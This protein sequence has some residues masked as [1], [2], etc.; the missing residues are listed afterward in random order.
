MTSSLDHAIP[1][2]LR[3]TRTAL[4]AKP[5]PK[6]YDN[7]FE[8]LHNEGRVADT[9]CEYAGASAF[10]FPLDRGGQSYIVLVLSC[11]LQMK[12]E[13]GSV[14]R[15]MLYSTRVLSYVPSLLWWTGRKRCIRMASIIDTLRVYIS[16][17]F[18]SF[19][20]LGCGQ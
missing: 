7:S 5:L 9:L 4:S 17:M 14:P 15:F 1:K 6:R 20:D 12:F 18:K 19:P 2:K 13:G 11:V 10:G 16:I 8:R 3:S